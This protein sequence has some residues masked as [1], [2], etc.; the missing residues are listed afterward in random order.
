[1]GLGVG[2]RAK[3]VKTSPRVNCSEEKCVKGSCASCPVVD[4]SC[5][6][7]LSKVR[8]LS[9]ISL[10]TIVIKIRNETSLDTVEEK[11]EC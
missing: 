2:R 7:I 8:T 11:I 5:A 4:E 6:R 3:H 10:Y 1:M 9:W